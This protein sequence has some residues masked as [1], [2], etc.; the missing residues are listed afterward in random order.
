MGARGPEAKTKDIGA[1]VASNGARDEPPI[2]RATASAIPTNPTSRL[3]PSVQP[4]ALGSRALSPRQRPD[5]M[6]HGT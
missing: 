4:G 2:A 6:S 3:E 1:T 5:T